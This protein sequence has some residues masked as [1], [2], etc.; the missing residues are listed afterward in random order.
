MVCRNDGEEE[1]FL[2]A[3]AA[4]RE[5]T[6]GRVNLRFSQRLSRHRIVQSILRYVTSRV[7][8]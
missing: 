4:G 2:W 3:K 5:E 6:L 7:R 8:W 1:R